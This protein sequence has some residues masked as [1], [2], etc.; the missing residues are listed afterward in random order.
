VSTDL[1]ALDTV[2]VDTVYDARRAYEIAQGLELP[3]EIAAR[4][5]YGPSE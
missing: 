2:F 4:Y 5:G 3:A 1:A